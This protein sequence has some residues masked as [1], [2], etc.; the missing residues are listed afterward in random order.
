MADLIK[1]NEIIDRRWCV[2][3]MIPYA[4]KSAFY[5][6]F[7]V[8]C[9]AVDRVLKI[10]RVSDACDGLLNEI[11]LLTGGIFGKDVA[12]VYGRGTHQ[13][14]P[15]VVLEI[16]EPLPDK[17]PEKHYPKLGL[18]IIWLYFR[19]WLHGFL[20][21]DIKRDNIMLREGRPVAIDLEKTCR[22]R[23]VDLAKTKHDRGT[24]GYNAM[25]LQLGFGRSVRTEISALADTL[26]DFR[27]VSLRDRYDPVLSIGTENDEKLRYQSFLAFAVAFATAP[28]RRGLKIGKWV[29]IALAIVV[30]AAYAT[31]DWIAMHFTHRTESRTVLLA[32]RQ[33]EL[34]IAKGDADYAQKIN[35][36]KAAAAFKSY[37]KAL[38]HN[39]T[40]DQERHIYPRLFDLIDV[41][42][43]I[44]FE[45]E[46]YLKYA[47]KAA[48]FG[49]EKAKKVLKALGQA[50]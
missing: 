26:K 8:F 1:N 39:P 35:P 37:K 10:A 36:S 50:L 13:G 21:G 28:I 38:S 17:I 3:G 16:L 15:Y 11:G 29:L 32:Q 44:P 46:E 27:P 7:D 49:N 33:G 14:A 23:R 34:F 30:L 42:R 31:H 41:C 9:P 43:N 18:A 24:P 47:E 2:V 6:V 20:H 48:E 12:Q 22:N 5:I 25:E 4:G 45:E 40:P 19:L